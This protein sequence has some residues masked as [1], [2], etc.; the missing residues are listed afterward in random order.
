MK[1]QT[2]R[3]KST[4]TRPDYSECSK[5]FFHLTALRISIKLFRYRRL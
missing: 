2:I 1:L 5:F 3:V 4:D